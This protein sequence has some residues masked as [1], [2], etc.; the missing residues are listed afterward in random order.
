MNVLKPSLQTTIKTLL[1]KQISQREIERKTGIDRKTIRRYARLSDLS[2]TADADNSKSPTSPEV[3]TGSE[4][5]CVQNPPPRPPA[6]E[7]KI[8]K[9]V[10]A[11][12]ESHRE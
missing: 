8:P 6:S 11:A 1:S 9:H 12:C 4:T 10:R 7:A 5:S 2:T 3:A